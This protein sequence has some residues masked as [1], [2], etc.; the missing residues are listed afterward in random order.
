MPRERFVLI[1][2]MGADERLFAPQRSYGFE[3]E[4][5]VLPTPKAGERMADFAVRLRD[6]IELTGP[7]V[8]G[9]VS[10]GGMLAC[11]LARVSSARCAILIASCRKRSSLPSRYRVIELASR[12]VPDP[13]I[14][15]RALISGRLLAALEC[16]DARQQETI[17]RMSSEVA[18]PHLRRIARMML[19]WDPPN[20]WPCPIYHIH[21]DK[22]VL[23]PIGGVEPD[24]IIPG[25]GHLINMT[26]PEQVNRF[27]ERYLLTS[28]DVAG[29][30]TF[31]NG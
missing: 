24:E 3:F 30:T 7:C 8:V 4:V 21:G 13:L 11:E 5:P 25:G 20:R 22:D 1:P 19:Q 29:Q 28:T 27:I 9:G 16:I 31:Q 12:L 2:G 15:R 18:V 10:F 6:S 14:K 26:H 23:I 17:I